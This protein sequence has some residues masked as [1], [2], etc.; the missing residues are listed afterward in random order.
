MPKTILITGASRGIGAATAFLAAQK[1][2][3][4]A[5]N[6]RQNETAA[7]AVVA[8]IEAT[9][10]IARAYRADVSIEQE[11]ETLFQ[12]VDQDFGALHALVN[13]VGILERQM[14]VEDMDAGRLQR[15]FQANV[16]SC[17]FCCREAVRRMSTKHGGS[18]GAIV[19]VSSIAAKTGSP[20][21]YVDYAASKSAMDVLTIG[22]AKE[23]AMEGIRVNCVRPGAVYTDIHADGGEPERIERVKQAIPMQ[24]GGQPEEIAHA[25]LWLL[26]ADSSYTSGALFDIA[27]G[28]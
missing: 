25:I 5:V 22:L 24:R 11:V 9:G 3:Q 13:N 26:S 17:F 21:E 8:A 16:F 14:R 28:K 10:G 2:Y 15:V 27:G 7:T 1:G 23:V 19:N 20:N 6:Y 18:G 4:V 12:Q